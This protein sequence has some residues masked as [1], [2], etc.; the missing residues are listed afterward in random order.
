MSDKSDSTIQ[1]NS[2]NIN[3]NSSN[4]LFISSVIKMYE[5]KHKLIKVV[6]NGDKN[7]MVFIVTQ[8]AITIGMG[9][10]WMVVL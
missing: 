10:R 6:E 7:M 4:Q 8:E 1:T 3:T 9:R 5:K 2:I